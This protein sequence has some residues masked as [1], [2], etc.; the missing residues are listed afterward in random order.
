MN[1]LQA[2]FATPNL[3]PEIS[4]FSGRPFIRDWPKIC[5]S[6]RATFFARRLETECHQ[7]YRTDPDPPVLAFGGLSIVKGMRETCGDPGCHEAEVRLQAQRSPDWAR[8]HGHSFPAQTNVEPT[9]SKGL[10]RIGK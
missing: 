5:P 3:A 7:P 8:V 1:S 10:K 9:P 6:C 4:P 2:T